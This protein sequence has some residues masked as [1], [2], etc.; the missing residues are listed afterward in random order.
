MKKWTDERIGAALLEMSVDGQLPSNDDLKRAGMSGL[1]FAVSKTGG[2]PDWARKLGLK[3]KGDRSL[4]NDDLIEAALR[5]DETRLGRMPTANELRFLGQN[6]LACAISK[7]GGFRFW[8]CRLGLRQKGTETHRGQKWERHEAAFFR[9]MGFEVVEQ[10]TRAPFDLLVNGHCVD[11][12][13]STRSGWYQFG[14]I[15]R[16]SDCDFFDLLCVHNDEVRARFVVPAD[17]ACVMSITIMPN[18][19]SGLGKYAAFRD[20]IHLVQ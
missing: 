15:K 13:S 16:G 5:L 14:S 11:V 19:L 2:Y 1:G 6:D 10:P 7:H 3:T 9:S 4:W 17:K 18:T 8:A 12:K 20:A